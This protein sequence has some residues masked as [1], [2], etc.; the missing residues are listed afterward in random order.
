MYW[1][2]L[3]GKKKLWCIFFFPRLTHQTGRNV[4]SCDGYWTICAER[5]EFASSARP[6][7]SHALM[8]MAESNLN[9]GLKGACRDPNISSVSPRL[10]FL[11]LLLFSS[12]LLPPPRRLL[13]EYDLTIRREAFSSC[14][15]CFPHTPPCSPPSSSAVSST[16]CFFPLSRSSSCYLIPP[17]AVSRRPLC[18]LLFSYLCNYIPS[19]RLLF[20]QVIFK[21]QRRKLQANLLGLINLIRSYPWLLC[22]CVFFL[23]ILREHLGEKEVQLSLMFDAVDEADLANYTCYVENHIGRRSG[24]AILQ[25]KG[26]LLPSSS[27]PISLL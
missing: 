2:K 19:L 24:S 25:K 5:P 15:Q 26:K 14:Q 11:L 8:F 23:R 9:I 6:L 21:R 1:I 22:T 12:S 13:E 17:H 16:C 18:P 3:K 7:W 10:P 20:F 4:R 27:P